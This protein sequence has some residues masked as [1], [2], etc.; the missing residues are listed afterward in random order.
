MCSTAIWSW[1]RWAFPGELYLGGAGL[2]RGYFNRPGLTAE[3][4]V[5]NPFVPTSKGEAG[6]RLYRTGDRVRWRADGVLEFLGRLDDQIKLRG[7]RI[8]PGEI[9]VALREH[10]AVRAVAVV[11]R[12]EAPG[13]R[14]LVAYVV[15]EGPAPGS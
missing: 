7:H 15:P 4:F 6:G 9:E 11:A 12:E 8:E 1:C 14:R 2:A 13:G 5:P 3:R 10:P